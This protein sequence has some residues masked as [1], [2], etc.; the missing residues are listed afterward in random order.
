MST[1]SLLLCGHACPFAGGEAC[2]LEKGHDGE[3]VY[4]TQTNPTRRRARNGVWIVDENAKTVMHVTYMGPATAEEVC[5][6]LALRDLTQRYVSGCDPGD[7]ELEPCAHA[8]ATV[9]RLG[10]P[11]DVAESYERVRVCDDCGAE[12]VDE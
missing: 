10:G 5:A 3:H 4:W 1:P 8:N 9:R 6:I 11:P 2:P 7:E 12:V